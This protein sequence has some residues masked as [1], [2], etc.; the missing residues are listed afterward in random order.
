VPIS[1]LPSSWFHRFSSLQ[2]SLGVRKLKTFDAV[3][4][5]VRLIADDLDNI[6][7][8]RYRLNSV[9]NSKSIRWQYI[10]F[11]KSFEN[12]R[13]FFWKYRIDVC[14][15]SLINISDLPLYGW[16]ND[17]FVAKSIYDEAIYIPFYPKLSNKNR[18]Q[19]NRSLSSYFRLSF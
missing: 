6:I 16:N 19:L 8:I 15:T 9:S 5:K 14:R 3:C 7:P 13:S 12:T 11:S 2:A 18:Q 4:E 10:I 1:A 17:F